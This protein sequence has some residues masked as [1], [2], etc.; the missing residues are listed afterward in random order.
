MAQ[1]QSEQQNPEQHANGLVNSVFYPLG[2]PY[3][4]LPTDG[5]KQL[6]SITQNDLVQYSKDILNALHMTI[7]YVGPKL[8]VGEVKEV[9]GLFSKVKRL[10]VGPRLVES[11]TFNPKIRYAFEHRDIPTAY[12]RLK[13]NSPGAA[14]PDAAA[15]R[16][17]FEILSEELHEEVRTKRSLSYAIQAMTAQFEQ[18]IGV[19]A[20]ST[21]KPQETIKAMSDVIK[22]IKN[23]LYTTEKVREYKNVFTTSHFLTLEAHDS[24]AAALGGAQIYLGDAAKLYSFQKRIDEVDNI[25]IQKIA[26]S[27]LTNFRVAVIYDE[28]QFKE[29]WLEPLYGL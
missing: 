12:I 25:Q 1:Y 28:K 24:Y 17:M 10:R 6:E 3:R 22:K 27:V 16:V 8:S 2:H 23:T 19:I 18:G 14:S 11:P 15:S 13:F 26:Q 29:S 9:E 5:I 21:S 7:I 20:A 4:H